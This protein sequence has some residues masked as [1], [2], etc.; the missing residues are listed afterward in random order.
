MKVNILGIDYKVEKH[1]EKEDPKLENAN[2]Y[3]E[4]YSKKIVVEEVQ[5]YPRNLEEIGK[6]EEKVLRHEIVHTFLHE[7][8]LD[9]CSGWAT[10]EEIV[11]WIALQ[12]PKLVSVFEEAN[13]L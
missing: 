5:H 1:L 4:T 9:N 8:G 3:C 12:A 13:C 2:G 7:S 11:D 10:N 6:F